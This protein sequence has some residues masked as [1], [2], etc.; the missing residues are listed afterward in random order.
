[1][2]IVSESSFLLGVARPSSR[3]TTS[4]AGIKAL[5]AEQVVDSTSIIKKIIDHLNSGFNATGHIITLSSNR[6]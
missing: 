3:L 5:V 4:C 1:M 2:V 6:D